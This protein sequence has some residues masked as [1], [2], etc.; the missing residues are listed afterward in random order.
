M[1]G[2]GFMFRFLVE[3]RLTDGVFVLT[4]VSIMN[5]YTAT[6]TKTGNSFA[7][8]VPKKY[9]ED[10]GLELGQKV[11]VAAPVADLKQHDRKAIGRAIRQLREVG[12]YGE[13]DDPV[14]WQRQTRVDRVMPERDESV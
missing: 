13:I 4:I 10:A 9:V 12:A 7:L 5:T 6:V 2:G 1:T 11:R 8:R 3:E 14:L